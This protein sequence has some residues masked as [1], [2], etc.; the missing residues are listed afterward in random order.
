MIEYR[1]THEVDL[2]QL[3]ALFVTAG[4][5]DRAYP[6]EKLAAVVANS[7]FIVSAWEG[8]RLIGFARA[9][10]DG[11]MNAYVSTVAVLPDWRGRGIGR[12]IVRRLVEGEG[13]R[14]IRWVLHARG[15]LHGFYALNG[16]EPAPDILWKDR[17]R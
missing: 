15:E 3:A 4:W 8:A 9:V 13:K 17:R 16:F 12:E 1:D 6:R 5:D 11:V 10:S 7:R 14:S 2:E